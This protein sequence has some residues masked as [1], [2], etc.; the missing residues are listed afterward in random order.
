[1]VSG[2]TARWYTVDD[3][4]I[5]MAIDAPRPFL[6]FFVADDETAEKH[7]PRSRE[8]ISVLSSSKCERVCFSLHLYAPRGN[9]KAIHH[10]CSSLPT[11]EE[12]IVCAL[13]RLKIRLLIC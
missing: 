3:M 2:W 10:I 13:V 6:L 9:L 8:N 4:D 1:M 7:A 11:E 5:C 12:R